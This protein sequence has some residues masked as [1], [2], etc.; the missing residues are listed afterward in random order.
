MWRPQAEAL[1]AAG[2]PAVT[3]D[4]PGH[5]TRIER[6]FD[7]DDAVAAVEE[8]VGGARAADAED[9]PVVLVGFS[10][11]GFVSM[12]TVGR[13]PEL[14]DGL[15]A[16]GCSTRPNR[17]GLALYR[18]WSTGIARLPDHGLALDTAVTSAV[19]G[20]RAAADVLAGGYGIAQS[21]AAVAAVATLRPL[22][23]VVRAAEAGLPVWFVN[24]GLDHFRLEERLFQR[25]T[26]GSL[27]T[28]VPGV[29]HMASLARPELVTTILL[30]I[31]EHV[32]SP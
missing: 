23:S 2:I 3:V 28:V 5:G 10:L 17:L 26:P 14:V 7:I 15:V 9:G 24:G 6:A 31:A 18:R 1:A 29:G 22:E 21:P 19:L 27:L 11:G 32:S 4:L 12:E 25:S 8:G 13:R 20:A 30:A 16:L